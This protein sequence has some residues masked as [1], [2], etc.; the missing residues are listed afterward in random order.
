MLCIHL[1]GARTNFSRS[2]AER[3]FELILSPMKSLR[4]LLQS[5]KGQMLFENEGRTCTSP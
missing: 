3:L 5:A 2:D 4:V 1:N